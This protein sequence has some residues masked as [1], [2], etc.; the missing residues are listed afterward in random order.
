[1]EK[2]TIPFEVKQLKAMKDGG[3]LIFNHPIQRR[4]GQWSEYDKGLLIH[5]MLS[6]YII[7]P[8][9]L[10]KEYTGKQDKKHRPINNYSVLDGKQRLSNVFDFMD[11]KYKIH[12]DIPPIDFE[13]EDYEIAGKLF[14]ELPDDIQENIRRYR[15]ILYNLENCTDDEIEECFIRLNNGVT[16]TKSQK[17]KAKLG[18]SISRFIDSVLER[19]FFA[20]VCHFTAAQFRRAADQCTLLQAMMLLDMK[21]NGFELKSISE[22]HIL[23]Y[24][25]SLHNNYSEDQQERI[26]KVMDYLEEAFDQKEKF[27]KKINV[28]MFIYIADEAIE[29]GVDSADFYNWFREFADAYS[30]DCEYSQFCSTGS[31]KKEKVLGRIE[32]LES[33]FDKYMT[34]NSDEE[35]AE[36]TEETEVVEESKTEETE[37]NECSEEDDEENALPFC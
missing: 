14:S 36:E 10:I 27:M 4:G 23:E 16:L 33:S 18:M 2:S 12:E 22:T 34:E 28:P 30:P 26:E 9:Y 21:H 8:V 11:D 1:M 31:I 37:Q 15:F 3:T 25:E 19:K 13:E 7:P 32:V 17:S 35:A 6:G 29:N 20:N 5:S 24:A